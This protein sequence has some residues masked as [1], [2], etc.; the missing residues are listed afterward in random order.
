MERDA[1]AAGLCDLRE[2]VH[3]IVDHEVAVQRTIHAVHDRRDR[4][5]H[6][7][8]HRDRLDEMPVADVEMEDPHAAAQQDVHL[9][10]EPREV[11]RIDGGLDLDRPHP[12]PPAHVRRLYWVSRAMKKPLVP[13][14]YGRVRR[15]SGRRGWTNCGHS[16]P[17]GTTLSPLASTTASFSSAFIVQ[18]E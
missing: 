4:P 14:P 11:G 15:N 1:V 6:D 3:R 12:V 10:A 13:F 9:V 8:A 7:R 17:S 2:V 16:S 18:T 5:Q